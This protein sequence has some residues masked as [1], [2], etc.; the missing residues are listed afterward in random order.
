MNLTVSIIINSIMKKGKYDY[1]RNSED[2][3]PTQGEL[4][5]FA[6]SYDDSEYSLDIEDGVIIIDFTSDEEVHTDDDAEQIR[7]NIE[8]TENVSNEVSNEFVKRYQLFC[9]NLS[10]RNIQLRLKMAHQWVLTAPTLK[11]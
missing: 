9:K 5:D 3:Y 11:C 2:E 8:F 4:K 10:K 6:Y 7:K 1:N